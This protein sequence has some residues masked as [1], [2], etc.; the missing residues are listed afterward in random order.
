MHLLCASTSSLHLQ[1]SPS[2]PSLEPSCPY[3]RKQSSRALLVSGQ[4]QQGL[5]PLGFRA[6]TCLLETSACGGVGV[7]EAAGEETV[8]LEGEE[9]EEEEPQPLWSKV[10]WNKVR[11]CHSQLQVLEQCDRSAI[12]QCKDTHGG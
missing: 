3:L 9:E 2:S 12:M 7:A 8:E 10:A 1:P 6:V 4:A 5:M 11:S